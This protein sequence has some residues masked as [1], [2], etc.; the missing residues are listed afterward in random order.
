METVQKILTEKNVY[1]EVDFLC[2]LRARYPD[3]NAIVRLDDYVVVFWNEGIKISVEGSLFEHR[4]PNGNSGFVILD[5]KLPWIE[6]LLV[7]VVGSYYIN[8]AL[9]STH[10]FDVLKKHPS[11]GWWLFGDNREY[12]DYLDGYTFLADAIVSSIGK[13]PLGHNKG[14]INKVLSTPMYTRG[15]TPLDRQYSMI[16]GFEKIKKDSK[17]Y[18]KVTVSGSKDSKAIT[19]NN[20]PRWVFS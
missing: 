8:W 13:L 5:G 20:I 12:Q 1:H 14:V 9:T 7:A 19:L 3:A 2:A 15:Y 10:Q 18:E 11:K 17:K 16:S 4:A 6:D